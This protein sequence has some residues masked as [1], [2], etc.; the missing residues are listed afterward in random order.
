M[1]DESDIIPKRLQ[2]GLTVALQLVT[3]ATLSDDRSRNV[4]VSE[5]FVRMFVEVC[6]SYKQ[7]ISTNESG[8]KTFEV[9]SLLD[10]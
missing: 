5:A 2:K 1:G 6:G 9:S 3:E 8:R 4:L 10:I 7:F